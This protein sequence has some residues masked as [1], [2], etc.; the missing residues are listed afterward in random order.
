MMFHFCQK[1]PRLQHVRESL[2]RNGVDF[3]QPFCDTGELFCINT[4]GVPDTSS[5]T[6]SGNINERLSTHNAMMQSGLR[7]RLH[8]LKRL[9]NHENDNVRRNSTKTFDKSDL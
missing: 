2:K 5:S 3:D 4:I 8:C 9:F 7:R 1:N 6:S